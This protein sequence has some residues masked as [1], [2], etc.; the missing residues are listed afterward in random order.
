MNVTALEQVAGDEEFLKEVLS[1]LLVESSTAE[2]D[3]ENAIQAKNFDGI[4]KSAHRFDQNTR[5]N[6]ATNIMG[7]EQHEHRLILLLKCGTCT[8]DYR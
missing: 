6:K 4:M 8:L 2:Q 3:L 5:T 7:F 1:D